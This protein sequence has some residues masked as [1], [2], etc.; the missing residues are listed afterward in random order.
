VALV[1]MLLVAGSGL[2]GRYL[3]GKF[4]YGLYGGQV[5]LEQIREDLDTLVI[6]AGQSS[7]DPGAPGPLRDLHQLCGEIIANQRDTVSLRQLLRQRATLIKTRRD[8]LLQ[9]GRDSHGL[10]D[11][12][13]A[14]AGLLDKLAGLRLFERLFALWHVI[15]IP[16][17]LLMLITAVVHIFV[18]HWF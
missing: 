6:Q 8:M 10:R 7:S 11:H 5:C 4:H 16:V 17:F 18:V 14:L 12:Y 13:R 15:H 1:A 2:I 9:P 3:Y